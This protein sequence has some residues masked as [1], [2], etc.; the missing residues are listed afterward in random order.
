MDRL[1]P[2]AVLGRSFSLWG[3]HFLAF[4]AVVVAIHLPML[5]VA[6]VAPGAGE[7]RL[8][9]VLSSLLG[10]VAAGA[11]T[12]GTLR[13]LRGEVPRVGEMARAGVARV[14]AVLGASILS[15]IAIV[16]GA[17]LLLVPGV[18]LACATAVAIPVTI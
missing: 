7:S 12:A 11:L 16:L 18:I 5:L 1:S 10:L 4:T 17:L 6:A 8:V 15:G 14:W 9:S 2:G 3:R 13:G